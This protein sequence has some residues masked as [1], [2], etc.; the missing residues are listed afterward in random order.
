MEFKL[1]TYNRNVPDEDFIEDMQ[2]VAKFL[3][4][5]Y[6]THEDYNKHGKYHSTTIQ[7]RFNGWS[8]ACLKSE[9]LFKRHS[10]I[11]KNDIISDI[12]CA[13]KIIGKPTFTFVEY[14]KFGDFNAN[15]IYRRFKTWNNAL[16]TADL[17]KNS[18]RHTSDEK[19]IA[20]GE[21]H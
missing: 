14:S 17:N 19:L 5:N 18:N 2:R 16:I 13:A 15:A 20:V 11:N 4:Q 10:R 6:L 21:E 3:K 12:K 7:K 8:N 1:N 9:L